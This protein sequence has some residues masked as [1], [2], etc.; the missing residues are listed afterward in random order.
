MSGVELLKRHDRKR[1]LQIRVVHERDRPT[2]WQ[3]IMNN[4]V[5]DDY[6]TWHLAEKERRRLAAA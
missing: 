4:I 2:R 3:L 5:H 1:V 6:E